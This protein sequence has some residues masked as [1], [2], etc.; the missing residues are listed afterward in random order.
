MSNFR[1][2]CTFTMGGK[3]YEV[4]SANGNDPASSL[5]YAERQDIHHTDPQTIR[6]WKAEAKL[7][8]GDIMLNGYIEK[9]ANR[10]GFFPQLPDPLAQIAELKRRIRAIEERRVILLKSEDPT[11]QILLQDNIV[12]PN[13]PFDIWSCV[14]EDKTPHSIQFIKIRAVVLSVA[15]AAQTEN[16]L[17]NIDDQ[18]LSACRISGDSLF[19]EGKVRLDL[20]PELQ[21]IQGNPT[22]ILSHDLGG[23]IEL[24]IELRLHC[25]YL[26]GLAI[27]NANILSASYTRDIK[28]PGLKISK[29]AFPEIGE[30]TI[31]MEGVNLDIYTEGHEA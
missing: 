15:S 28:A 31:A 20:S 14:A 11:G 29:L 23:K 17:F 30:H 6:L 21:T 9:P 26:T 3:E 25:K 5:V 10:D 18:L 16:F 24:G 27:V 7:A 8:R 19:C 1:K 13:K 22:Q 4:I 12:R 2:G